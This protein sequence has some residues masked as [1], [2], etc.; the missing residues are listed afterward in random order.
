ML[1][2]LKP[3]KLKACTN[4]WNWQVYIHTIHTF[5][6]I[7]IQSQEGFIYREEG[8]AVHKIEEEHCH[9]CH[10]G[11]QHNTDW[12]DFLK[13]PAIWQGRWL[14]TILWNCHDGTCVIHL[15]ILVAVGAGYVHEKF[16]QTTALCI[17]AQ[18]SGTLF[19]RSNLQVFLARPENKYIIP[20]QIQYPIDSNLR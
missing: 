13:L 15:G 9:Q 20:V 18:Y 7:E 3:M 10:V 14:H 6:Q 17:K 2:A 19:T 11:T 16:V 1:Q 12:K 5:R 4:H 8:S